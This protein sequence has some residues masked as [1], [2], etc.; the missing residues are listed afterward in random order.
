MYIFTRFKLLLDYDEVQHIRIDLTR[1]AKKRKIK[2]RSPDALQILQF[3]ILVN[4]ELQ[5][6]L[7]LS[8]VAI[9]PD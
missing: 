5:F 6:N 1:L 8:E 4:S 9:S 7:G 3:F 2:E